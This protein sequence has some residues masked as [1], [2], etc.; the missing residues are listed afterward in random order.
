MMDWQRKLKEEFKAR[1]PQ[2]AL[3][4][5]SPD[6]IDRLFEKIL[7]HVQTSGSDELT[8]DDFDNEMGIPV[9]ATF[10]PGYI[11]VPHFGRFRCLESPGNGESVDGWIRIED[12]K[13]YFVPDGEQPTEREVQ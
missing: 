8:R 4:Q 1:F 7:R 6:G 11:F 2:Y 12:G 10:G 13:T 9:R 5:I 3:A